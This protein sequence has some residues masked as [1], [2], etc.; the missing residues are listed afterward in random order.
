MP[1]LKSNTLFPGSQMETNLLKVYPFCVA[2][3]L[4]I[5]LEGINCSLCLTRVV[6]ND[7]INVTFVCFSNY[8]FIFVFI[9][10]KSTAGLGFGIV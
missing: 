3:C 6:D 8:G 5:T 7:N 1:V 4:Q 10:Y 9:F 2:P